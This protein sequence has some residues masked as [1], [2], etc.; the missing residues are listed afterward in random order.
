MKPSFLRASAWISPELIPH[1]LSIIG[2]GAVGSNT[3]LLAAKMGFTQFQLW[4]FDQV[5]DFN[6]PNQAFN[7][8][9]IGRPKVEAL[10]EVLQEFN[11][12]V[13]VQTFNRRFDVEEDKPLLKGP[14]VLATDSISS[15]REITKAFRLN[16]DI[17][18]VVEARLAF[19]AAQIHTILPMNVDSLY[20]WNQTLLIDDNNI[21]EGPCNHRMCGTLVYVVVGNIVHKLCNL[22]GVRREGPEWIPPF[23]QQLHLSAD[24]YTQLEY[25]N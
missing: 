20:A 2:C 13:K 15:R 6:L 16:P 23:R 10:Q 1:P 5:E 14:V 7:P 25:L 9:H 18:L 22:Y 17:P 19:D 11:P 3:A 21:E 12:A 4:D 24:L 8:S